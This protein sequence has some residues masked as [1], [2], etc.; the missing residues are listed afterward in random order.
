MSF[1]AHLFHWAGP[2]LT[3]QTIAEGA[4][5]SEQINGWVNPN[6][7]PG[8][9]CCNPLAQMWK[10]GPGVYT[11]WADAREIYWSGSAV[12]PSNNNP[13]AWVC[14]NDCRRYEVGQAWIVQPGREPMKFRFS[15]LPGPRVE[16][17]TGIRP[18]S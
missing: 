12:S 9:K 8:W 14:V 11:A 6:P 2:K 17:R 4:R 7:W 13:G 16:G 10:L 18:P 15:N 5:T 1:L 3:P